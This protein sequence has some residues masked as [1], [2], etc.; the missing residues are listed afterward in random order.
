MDVICK[1]VHDEKTAVTVEFVGDGGDVISVQMKKSEQSEVDRQ[2]AVT[3]AKAL[4]VQVA[5]FEG[6]ETSSRIEDCPEDE[7]PAVVSLRKEQEVQASTSPEEQLE[8]GLDGTFP[9][10]DPVSTTVSSIPTGRTDAND[11]NV[12]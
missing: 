4:M 5:A 9:A 8:E 10:S 11:E 6:E 1:Q 12:A 2:N 3:K 7:S